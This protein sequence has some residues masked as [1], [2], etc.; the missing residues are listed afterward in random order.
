MRIQDT[1]N[2]TVETIRPEESAETAWRRMTAHRMR[3]LVVV[4]GRQIVG[5]VSDRDLG[6][7]EA[8]VSARQGKAVSDVMTPKP[9]TVGPTTTIR[10]AANLLR[11]RA[12]S[13]LPVVDDGRLVG[14][15][16][17]TD[18]LE[19][20]GRGAERPIEVGKR[21]T[22]KHRGPRHQKHIR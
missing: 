12:I 11:G 2:S 3:H 6:G 20:V 14:I 7:G 1:M 19:L 18:L 9:V 16:T 10:E 17:T 8:G 13:C 21:W 5:V 15:V 22:L 4:D